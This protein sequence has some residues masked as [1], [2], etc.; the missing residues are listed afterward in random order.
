MD[1]DTPVFVPFGQEGHL[2]VTSKTLPKDPTALI[3]QLNHHHVSIKYWLEIALLY[4]RNKQDSQFQQ[5]LESALKDEFQLIDGSNKH[6]FDDSNARYN[7]L[8][9]LAS[10]F[11]KLHVESIN[12]DGDKS[13]MESQSYRERGVKIHD[14]MQ[15]K[16]CNP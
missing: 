16:E 4:H 8:N 14:A 1:P 7:T 12:Y 2:K 10:H 11:F 15:Q 3:N 13:A 9:A 5:I 6:L